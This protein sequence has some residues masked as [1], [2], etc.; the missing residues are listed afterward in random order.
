MLMEK[1]RFYLGFLCLCLGWHPALAQNTWQNTQKGP[2]DVDLSAVYFVEG[3][4]GWVGGDNGYLKRT[5]DGGKTWAEQKTNTDASINDIYFLNKTDGFLLAG[6]VIRASKDGGKTWAINYEC[7]PQEFGATSAELYSIRFANKKKG[8]AVG[9]LS[10]T[11]K[12]RNETVERV[13]DSLLLRTEDGGQTWKRW[14]A[15][16]TDELI[17]LDIAGEKRA[18][19]VGANGV[20][21][22]TDSG[23]ESWRLQRANTRATLYHVDFRNDKNGFVV[24]QRGALFRTLD[25]GETW[26]P[27]LLPVQ[28][29]LLSVAIVNDDETWAV[30]R[31]GIILKTVDGG[32]T[33]AVQESKTK[34]NIY[35]LYFDKK[36]GFA[37]GAAGLSLTYERKN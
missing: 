17:H 18:W 31:G 29:T 5:E 20:I 28:N 7:N 35:A 33:W 25:G 9:S 27:V 13:L 8:W 26:I 34:S 11:E 23:G 16:V 6:S 24:G 12:R 37:V 4:H 22:F 32:V 10:V 1:A 19:I 14:R 2:A 3:K 36:L 15:P 21:I 30:G